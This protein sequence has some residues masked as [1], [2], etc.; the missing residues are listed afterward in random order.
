MG[1]LNEFSIVT[2]A[3]LESISLATDRY[4]SFCQTEQNSRSMQNRA[5]FECWTGF[6]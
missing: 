4:D 1:S 2:R 3:F 6:S 5:G